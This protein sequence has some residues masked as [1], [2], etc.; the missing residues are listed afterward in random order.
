MVVG[1]GGGRAGRDQH[2][3]VGV[4]DL[5]REQVEGVRS[6]DGGVAAGTE[7]ADEG[8]HRSAQR[9]A[10]TAVAREPVGQQTRTQHQRADNRGAHDL[11]AIESAR[12]G[13]GHDR[14]SD[15]GVGIHE[16]VTGGGDAGGPQDAVAQCW[17]DGLVGHSVERVAGDESDAA[18]GVLLHVGCV[19]L[20]H[21]VRVPGQWHPS[22][23]GRRPSG[24]Q[25]VEV[26]DQP[27]TLTADGESVDS[28]GVDRRIIHDG[29]EI[30]GEQ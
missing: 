20:Q 21:G 22:P 18:V 5:C 11:D 9:I 19:A 15:G 13:E 14:R 26:V 29:D 27:G 17:A 10:H 8:G 30:A 24:R 12:S 23:H 25:G 6:A 7:C 4:V 16:D 28:G 2:V 1:S 3:D